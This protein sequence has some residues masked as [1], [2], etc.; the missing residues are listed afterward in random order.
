M[1]PELGK[2]NKMKVD[3]WT[4]MLYIELDYVITYYNLIMN[5]MNWTIV[6][7]PSWLIVLSTSAWLGFVRPF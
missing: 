1:K 2:L 6:K 3:R 4:M 7:R 5:N